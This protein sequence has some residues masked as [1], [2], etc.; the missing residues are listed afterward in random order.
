M[1]K[2]IER[3]VEIRNLFNPAFCSIILLRSFQGYEEND[4]EGIPFSLSLLVLPLC[5]QK[6]TREIILT[7]SRSYLL[8]VLSNN[9]QVLLGFAQRTNNMIPF[10]FESLGL[11]MLYN[12]FNVTESGRLK[13]REGA[14][15]KS[16]KGTKES[17]DC[18]KAAQIIG[19]KFAQI[20]DRVTIYSSLG[21]RP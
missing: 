3:P 16:I 14:I 6:E 15:K 1:K 11:A 10:T 12:S 7:N 2:W 5:L 9:A 17:I 8:K 18:Q 20:S 21:I 4:D 19:K 13:L